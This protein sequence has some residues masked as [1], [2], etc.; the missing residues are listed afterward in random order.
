M[1]RQPAEEHTLTPLSYTLTPQNAD[2]TDYLLD[3]CDSPLHDF[4]SECEHPDFDPCLAAIDE[5]YFQSFTDCTDPEC[6]V[7]GEPDELDFDPNDY[8]Y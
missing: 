2:D 7:H 5:D 8:H 6:E 1:F 3:I 4:M